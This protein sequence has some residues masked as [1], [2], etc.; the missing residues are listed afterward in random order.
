MWT[1]KAE[2]MRRKLY[3]NGIME[4]GRFYFAHVTLTNDLK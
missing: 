3:L 2:A 1:D 4:F